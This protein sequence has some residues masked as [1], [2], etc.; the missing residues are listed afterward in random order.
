MGVFYARNSKG[1]QETHIRFLR[2]KYLILL[3]ICDYVY[4]CMEG[5]YLTY[6]INNFY[7]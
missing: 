6:I 1:T 7:N 5:G 2:K 3:V 4:A